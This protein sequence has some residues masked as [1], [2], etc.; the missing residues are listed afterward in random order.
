MRQTDPVF[1]A[2]APLRAALTRIGFAI[3]VLAAVACTAPR[4]TTAVEGTPRDDGEARASMPVPTT[5][6]NQALATLP[7]VGAGA[8]AFAPSGE[9]LAWAS[10]SSV[11]LRALASG[12]EHAFAAGGDV[13]DLGYAPDGALWIVAGTPALWR[14]G[15]RVCSAPGMQADRLLGA[16]VQG[17]VV[18]GYQHSDGVGMLRHQA[19][20]DLRCA[21]VR[22]RTDPLPRGVDDAE[23]D[24]GAPMLRT[25]LAPARRS[26][27]AGTRDRG[28]I[29]QSRDGAWQVV[30]TASGRILRA[31]PGL[32]R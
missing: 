23:A 8:V 19:W 2:K 15:Q 24:A 3:W 21:V 28:V 17:A 12:E 11:R 5:E 9:T 25:S 20:L 30:D 22:E 13:T 10:G 32:Q 1:S 4:S 31:T 6:T 18:A 27:A 29:A 7:L 14:D 26:A 16:D